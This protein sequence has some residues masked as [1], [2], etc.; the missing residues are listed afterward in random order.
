[1]HQVLIAQVVQ[2][3]VL[4]DLGTSL[5]PHGLTEGDA[6]LGQQLGGDAA[7]GAQHGPAGM[8]HL[9]LA[10][11]TEGLGVSG[12]TSGIPAIVAG[13]LTVQV[14]GGVTLAEGACKDAEE[15][16]VSV[17]ARMRTV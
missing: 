3:T 7:Q 2:A 4:E 16:D 9:Q 1:M 5:E 6:V 12:Q 15:I 10:E 13:E 11:A 8:D 14:G 17:P